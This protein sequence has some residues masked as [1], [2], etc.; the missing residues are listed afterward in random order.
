MDVHGGGDFLHTGDEVDVGVERV[1]RMHPREETD[2]GDVSAHRR[3]GLLPHGREVVAERPRV[4]GPPSEP[5]ES[6]EILADVRDVDVLVPDV[7]GDAPDLPLPEGVR[8][9]G[10]IPDVPAARLEE[11]HRLFLREPVAGEHVVEQ[12]VQ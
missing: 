6:A 7:G 8:R 2:L 3:P 12:F 4:A 10:D 5:A 9:G 1:V 11:T